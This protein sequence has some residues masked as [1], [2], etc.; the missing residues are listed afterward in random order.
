TKNDAAKLIGINRKTYV[1]IEN[2]S[3]ESIR[4]STYQKLVNWLLNDLKI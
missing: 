3:K 2:G 4:A 1:K